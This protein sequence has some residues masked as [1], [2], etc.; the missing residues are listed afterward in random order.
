MLENDGTLLFAQTGLE[1][2]RARLGEHDLAELLALVRLRETV[3]SFARARPHRERG[4][5][6]APRCAEILGTEEAEPRGQQPLVL[7]VAHHAVHF[8]DA[9]A[10]SGPRRIDRERFAVGRERG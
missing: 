9:C 6:L 1:R 10:R 5:E 3:G 2:S 7:G 4:Y 8:A